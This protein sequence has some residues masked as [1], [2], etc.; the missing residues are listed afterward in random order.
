[1][2]GPSFAL[3]P[4]FAILFNLFWIGALVLWVVLSIIA[5][6]SLRD[7]VMDDTAKAIWAV[8]V[9]AVPILGPVALWIVSPGAKRTP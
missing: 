2:M 5:L 1:M 6:V 9:I 7:R 3:G 8:A 4:L